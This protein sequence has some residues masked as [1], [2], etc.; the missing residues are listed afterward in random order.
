MPHIPPVRGTLTRLSRVERSGIVEREGVQ[1]VFDDRALRSVAF[2]QLREGMSVIFEESPL[3][4]TPR[5]RW[6]T[7]ESGPEAG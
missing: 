4:T 7:I 3:T 5:A 1:Y 6:V 2:E